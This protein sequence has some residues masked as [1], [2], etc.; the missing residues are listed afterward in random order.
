[1]ARSWCSVARS[2]CSLMR[3]AE[4]SSL[5]PFCCAVRSSATVSS[6]C[7]L[8]SSMAAFSSLSSS[9]TSTRAS[10]RTRRGASQLA[11]SV[12][13]PWTVNTRPRKASQRNGRARR[14]TALTSAPAG[15][16]TLHEFRTFTGARHANDAS[17][18]ECP[19]SAD[20]PAPRVRRSL[21][22]P[23]F[24]V[25]CLLRVVTTRTWEEPGCPRS[26]MAAFTLSARRN[27]Q[28][29]AG[30]GAGGCEWRR[31]RRGARARGRQPG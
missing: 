15:R 8:T 18:H 4:T 2:C 28:L 17:C 24:S 20:V 7:C 11:A 26:A 12:A 31:R 13:S 14:N 25:R 9:A 21:S 19:R 22:E 10:V 23:R 3:S 5:S 29:R 30:G 16:G 1:M 6:I 27:P